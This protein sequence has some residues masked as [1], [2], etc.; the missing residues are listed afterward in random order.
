MIGKL[1]GCRSVKQPAA[2]DHMMLLACLPL[3]TGRPVS[4]EQVNYRR[5]GKLEKWFT[6][7]MTAK[8]SLPCLPIWSFRAAVSALS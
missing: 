6:V 3:Q 2:V 1:A 8:R 5:D 7:A 4:P